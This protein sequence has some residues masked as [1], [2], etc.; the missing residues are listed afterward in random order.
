M[1]GAISGIATTATEVLC[2]VTDVMV[3]VKTSAAVA[4]GLDIKTVTC[5]MVEVHYIAKQKAG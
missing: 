1:P 2:A 4:T 3:R 5:A